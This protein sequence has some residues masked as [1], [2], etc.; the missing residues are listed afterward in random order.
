MTREENRQGQEPKWEKAI[1]RAGERKENCCKGNAEH[2]GI[3]KEATGPGKK[4]NRS[5]K[6]KFKKGRAN[7]LGG[8]G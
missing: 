1:V 6:I 7:A 3:V 4:G 5:G 8:V 2:L